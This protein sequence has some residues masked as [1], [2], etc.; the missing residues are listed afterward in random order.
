MKKLFIMT[1]IFTEHFN[2]N[3]PAKVDNEIK[4]FD[5]I[6]LMLNKK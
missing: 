4:I 3:I 5:F 2:G 6:S 1:L